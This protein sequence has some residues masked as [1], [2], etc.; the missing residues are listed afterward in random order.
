MKLIDV[1]LVLLLLGV[2]SFGLY[3]LWL[4]LPAETIT[5]EPVSAQYQENIS[6]SSKKSQI[7]FYPGMRYPSST[8][9]YQFEDACDSEKKELVLSAFSILSEK[10]LLNFIP[11]NSDA[12]LEIVCSDIAPTSEQKNHFIAGEGGPTSIINASKQYVILKGKISLFRNERCE[13]P[14]IALHEILHALGFDHN[15]NPDSIMYPVTNCGQVF[16]ESLIGAINEL[17]STPEGP[18]LA[19]LEVRASKSGRYLSF[20]ALVMNQ[21]LEDAH[22][23][24]F[25]VIADGELA[26]TF[27]LQT[28]SIGT[29]KSLEVENVPIARNAAELVFLIS[30][31]KDTS[32][33][34]NQVTLLLE[35]E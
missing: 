24:H 26:K 10:T 19:L 7:Q 29:R 34:N 25:S 8:I 1:I 16:D 31:E 14:N 32:M 35:D 2:L 21:G 6:I 23:V 18:D 13:T 28:I 12:R 27:S 3:V 4:Y 17:Y 11:A 15:Q 30:S 22:N 20:Q 9:S 5:Y 33:L